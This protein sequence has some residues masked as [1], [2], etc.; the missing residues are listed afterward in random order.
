MVCILLF[1]VVNEIM[2]DTLIFFFYY[3]ADP[4]FNY[5]NSMCV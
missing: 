1:L 3:E 4:F 2:V 5:N